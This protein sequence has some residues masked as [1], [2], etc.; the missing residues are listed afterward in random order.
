M[1]S[2]ALLRFKDAD[3]VVVSM[4]W[5][6]SGL[7]TQVAQMSVVETRAT[8][9]GVPQYRYLIEF[10]EPEGQIEIWSTGH[11]VRLLRGPVLSP[12]PFLGDDESAADWR[13]WGSESAAPQC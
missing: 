12:V 2:P 10:S 9:T 7:S 5:R 13:R 3:D 4:D 11:E 8:P 1:I 6:G